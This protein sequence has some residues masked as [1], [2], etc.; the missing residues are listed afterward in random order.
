MIP[1]ELLGSGGELLEPPPGSG[2]AARP[3]GSNSSGGVSMRAERQAEEEWGQGEKEEGVKG[4]RGGGLQ[5]PGG[6][7]V[8]G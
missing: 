7:G 5:C 4:S 2:R 3:D 6:V 8:E 1:F